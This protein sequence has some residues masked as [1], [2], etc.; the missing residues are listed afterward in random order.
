MTL[1]PTDDVAD[2]L[3]ATGAKETLASDPSNRALYEEVT[4]DAV[5]NGLYQKKATLTP[6]NSTACF[7]TTTKIY[8]RGTATIDKVTLPGG[9]EHW[10]LNAM[11]SR[12]VSY[13]GYVLAG[14]R[15]MIT[16]FNTP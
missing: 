3:K 5:Y 7:L 13:H 4:I 1:R 15:C 6:T 14:A 2:G 12:T 8:G 11:T 10:Q 16:P 9:K